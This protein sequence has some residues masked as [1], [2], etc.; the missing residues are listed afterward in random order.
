MPQISI[1]WTLDFG[2]LY[3]KC[4]LTLGGCLNGR[5]EC[6][7]VERREPSRCIN[8][9]QWIKESWPISL[10]KDVL[11]LSR[12]WNALKFS[13]SREGNNKIWCMMKV[14]SYLTSYSF[15]SEGFIIHAKNEPFLFRSKFE[16]ICSRLVFTM[17]PTWLST[18]KWWSVNI[19]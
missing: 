17:H 14:Y 3:L 16:L 10:L 2:Y 15:R 19:S 6:L 18:P 9:I 7:R 12:F 8:T 1:A 5:S 11:S 13:I 4:Q